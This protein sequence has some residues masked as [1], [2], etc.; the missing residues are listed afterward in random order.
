MIPIIE[1]QHRRS[2][3][4]IARTYAVRGGSD[5]TT[6]PGVAI[7]ATQLAHTDR[8]ALSQAWYSALH[9]AHDAPARSTPSHPSAANAAHTALAPSSPVASAASARLAPTA[10]PRA[11]HAPAA[12]ENAAPSMERRSAP[13]LAARRVERALATIA[14]RPQ[15][16]SSQTIALDGGRVT[17]LVRSDAGATRIVALC[18]E[19]LRATVERALAHARFALAAR[20]SAVRCV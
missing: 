10:A 11:S 13:T 18:G 19:P 9:L 2:A 20:G 7:V 4:L 14:G 6:A 16:R 15:P 3:T 5:M 8:R 12:R 17:L 1:R